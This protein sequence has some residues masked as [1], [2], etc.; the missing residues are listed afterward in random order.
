MKQKLLPNLKRWENEFAKERGRNEAAG[1]ILRVQ[2]QYNEL[3]SQAHRYDNKAL[4]HHFEGNILPAIAAYS[5][6]LADGSDPQTALQILDQLLEAQ[7]EPERRMYRFWGRFPFFFDMIRFMLKP[8]MK[9][10]YPQR[11]NVEWLDLGPDAVGLNCHACFYL[12]A[13]TEYGLPELTPHFCRL[14]DLLAAEAAPS[15]RFER[16]QTL[17]RGGTMCD[18][19]YVRVRSK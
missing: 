4:R 7:I 19:R 6:L 3:I 2:A 12:D 11:W 8:I 18:F 14:D 9:T 15:V 10:Q 17:A 13:L 16:T 1:F 5:T